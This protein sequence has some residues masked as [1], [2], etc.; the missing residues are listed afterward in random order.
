MAEYKV[1]Y[2]RWHYFTEKQDSRGVKR[3]VRKDAVRGEVLD[4][5]DLFDDDLERGLKHGALV[6]VKEAE[7][8][9]V[10]AINFEDATVPEIVEWLRENT[11]NV[12]DTV[13]ASGGDPDIA[14][15]LLD[16]E[17]EF[18]E[19]DPRKGV[20]DGLAEVISRGGQ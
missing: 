2:L 9:E 15:K 17:N 8:E 13:A 12:N 14:H 7:A 4:S 3:M 5:Q 16:A 18:Q 19:G 6:D 11:P 10:E 20:V 1:N